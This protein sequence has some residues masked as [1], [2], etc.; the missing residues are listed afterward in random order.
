MLVEVFYCGRKHRTNAH[1]V[2]N[3]ETNKL[4][5]YKGSIVSESVRQFSQTSRIKEL[6]EQYTDKN[7]LVLQDISLDSPSMAASFVTGYSID[8]LSAWHIDKHKTLKD[9]RKCSTEQ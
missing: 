1:G 3:P 9:V 4:T 2:Y 7:G 6:R 8:G 5:V